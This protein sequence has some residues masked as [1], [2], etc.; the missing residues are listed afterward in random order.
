MSDVV[1]EKITKFVIAIVLQSIVFNTYFLYFSCIIALSAYV[2]GF[3]AAGSFVCY[4]WLIG[5]CGGRTGPATRIGREK[6][7]LLHCV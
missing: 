2:C 1:S 7:F 4:V 6:Y 3:S 5:S